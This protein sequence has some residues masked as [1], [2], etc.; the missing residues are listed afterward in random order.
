V[1]EGAVEFGVATLPLAGEPES[2]DLHLVS[3]FPD[4]VLVAAVDGLGHGVEAAIAARAARETLEESPGDDIPTL[5]ERCH[6]RLAK[7]RGV[8]MS[9]ASFGV[10]D[11]V[12]TWLGVGNVEGTLL[13]A[14]AAASPASESILLR[15]GV[16][17][18]QLPTLRPSSTAVAPGDML[19]LA[20]DGVRSG[21]A[22]G[23]GLAEPVQGL[24]NR[25]LSSHGKET[26][27][28]LVLVARYLG[29][30]G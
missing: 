28:A 21:F 15:G 22:H 13:R 9:L 4:G 26:D 1:A 2:G 5:F 30:G 8:A 29:G 25:I 14:D 16:V 23:L 3:S 19:V 10:R 20:T 12:L 6:R 7:T 17:G 27:D 11:G 24:A 18:Y